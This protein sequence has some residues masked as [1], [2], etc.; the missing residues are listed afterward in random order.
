L[1]G[2]AL[3][4]LMLTQLSFAGLALTSAGYP[5]GGALEAL[6]AAA[7]VTRLGDPRVVFAVPVDAG[8]L[9]PGVLEHL[10]EVLGQVPG[11]KAVLVG[12]RPDP[13]AAAVGPARLLELVPGTG[14]LRTGLG[15]FGILVLGTGFT[16]FGVDGSV[17]TAVR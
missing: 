7:R 10:A 3:Q 2:D 14:V 13:R 9:S 1:F 8:W 4:H 5:A 16:A 12:G 15:A 17:R 6:E 11:P